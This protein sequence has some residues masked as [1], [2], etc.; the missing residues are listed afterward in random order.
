M[1]K[2]TRRMNTFE[3]LEHLNDLEEDDPEYCDVKSCKKLAAH[4]TKNGNFCREHFEDLKDEDESTTPS[5]P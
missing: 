4:R 5:K 3:Y 1:T 2:L